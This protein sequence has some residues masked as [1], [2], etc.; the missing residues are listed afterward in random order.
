MLLRLSAPSMKLFTLTILAAAVMCA[1]QALTFVKDPATGE[2]KVK[3]TAFERRW[4]IAEVN[5]WIKDEQAG[6]RPPRIDE[7]W[8]DWWVDSIDRN[9]KYLAGDIDFHV[10]Y[11]IEA[12]R[13]AG[14]PEL[15]YHRRPN[16]SL[17]P[18]PSRHDS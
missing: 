1:C 5:D 11:I 2:L 15:R 9:K 7:T 14:L 12:R 13:K 17:Q 8:N 18:T 6:L 16:K 10:N 3:D 4:F